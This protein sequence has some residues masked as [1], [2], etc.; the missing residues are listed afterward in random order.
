MGINYY[1]KTFKQTKSRYKNPVIGK[2][3][4]SGLNQFGQTVQGQA[5]AQ[6]KVMVQGI[7]VNSQR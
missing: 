6:G 2:Y 7:N 1:H 5:G 4:L 3:K